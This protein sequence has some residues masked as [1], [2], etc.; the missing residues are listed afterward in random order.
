MRRPADEIWIWL[1]MNRGRRPRWRFSL[2]E[3]PYFITWLPVFFSLLYSRPAQ[4]TMRK[5]NERRSKAYHAHSIY[6]IAWSRKKWWAE[7]RKMWKMTSAL[8]P[9]F[10]VTWPLKTP[11]IEL[12][13]F[14]VGLAAVGLAAVYFFY[15]RRKPKGL[16]LFFLLIAKN[17]FSF[18]IILDSMHYN[19]FSFLVRCVFV[20]LCYKK[21]QLPFL[22][23]NNLNFLY[24][25]R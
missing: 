6:I 4:R 11:G 25:S 20:C 2:L 22:Y 19:F 7:G 15:G 9:T 8:L 18:S 3:I 10:R 13:G 17:F 24:I 1:G 21:L 12:S 16:S 14:A 5:E 23:I